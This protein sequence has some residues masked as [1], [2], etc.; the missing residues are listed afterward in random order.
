MGAAS[1]GGHSQIGESPLADATAFVPHR[2]P[3]LL[4]DGI[5]STSDTESRAWVRVDPKAWYADVQG[6]MP[7]W[8]GIELM[9]QTV[10]AYSGAVK[11]RQGK[12]P[13]KGYLLGARTYTST[14]PAFP[15]GSILEI[16][17]VYHYS[18]DSGLWAFDC[19]I[20]IQ[21][22]PVA[23]AMLKVFEEK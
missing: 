4:L 5:R 8:Y 22:L 10:A 20:T 2:A 7:A 1:R 6:A 19:T 18:D 11:R 13:V 14:L 21:D 3:M 16:Q 9:A 23:T 15:A 17:G 12:P